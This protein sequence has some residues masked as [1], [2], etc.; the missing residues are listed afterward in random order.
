MCGRF[1]L[2]FQP[3]ELVETFAAEQISEPVPAS[4]NIAPTDNAN[5]ISSLEGKVICSKMSWG[6]DLKGS[7]KVFNARL[8]TLLEKWRFKKSAQSM[9]CLVPA[10]GW[11]E[12]TKAEDGGKDPHY[13]SSPTGE[14][15]ALGGLYEKAADGP[16]FTIITRPATEK[17]HHI[18]N[19]MP[20]VL[21]KKAWDLWLNPDEANIV[22]TDFIQTATDEFEFTTRVVSRKVNN[23][24]AEGSD[25]ILPI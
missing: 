6:F 16:R 11:Y 4:Y 5:I 18:H 12:W 10:S 24:R 23:S 2:G 17:L 22:G 21:P 7:A 19:R 9:R 1:S 15:L 14:L 13:F 3:E 20:L 8:E 25:L